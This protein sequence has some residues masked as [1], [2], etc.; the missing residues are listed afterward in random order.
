MRKVGRSILDSQCSDI[1]NYKLTYHKNNH[2]STLQKW[3]IV[4]RLTNAPF[5]RAAQ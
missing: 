4:C 3:F 1:G 2:H 5:N